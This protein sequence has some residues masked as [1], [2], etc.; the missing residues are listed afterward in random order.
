MHPEWPRFPEKQHD[1]KCEYFPVSPWQ[2]VSTNFVEVKE[3]NKMPPKL[4]HSLTTGRHTV[5]TMHTRTLCRNV[6]DEQTATWIQAQ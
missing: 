4:K 1:D 2:A 5:L 6:S 3:H